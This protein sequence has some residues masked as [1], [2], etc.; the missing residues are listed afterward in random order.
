VEEILEDIWN[1]T[2]GATIAS[3][4]IKAGILPVAVEDELRLLH[5]NQTGHQVADK[6]HNASVIDDINKLSLPPNT[7]ICDPG[8][9]DSVQGLLDLRVNC[10]QDSLVSEIEKWTQLEESHDYKMME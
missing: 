5:C 8:L 4:W 10:T 3:C 2:E 6:S 1:R 9:L 7:S